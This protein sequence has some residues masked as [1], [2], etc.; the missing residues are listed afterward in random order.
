MRKAG[1]PAN[2]DAYVHSLEGWVRTRVEA[3]RGAVASAAAEETVKWGHLVYIS[4]GPAFLI[5][6]EDDRVIFGFWRGQRLRELDPRLKPGGKYEMA[7]I[8]LLEETEFDLALA[9]QLA[10]AAVELNRRL[11]DPTK[12]QRLPA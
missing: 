9:A 7:R 8:D 11:G 3:L 6:A 10:A 4:N 12:L 1:S 2:P 5:R